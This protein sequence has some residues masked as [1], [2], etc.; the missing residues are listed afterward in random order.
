[1]LIINRIKRSFHLL[2]FSPALPFLLILLFSS[3]AQADISGSAANLVI[4][5]QGILPSSPPTAL[6]GLNLQTNAGDRLY[7]VSVT[8]YGVWGY[9]S[10][11]L[12]SVYL[13]HDSNYNH[14]FDAGDTLIA[15]A[16]PGSPLMVGGGYLIPPDDNGDYA[17]IDF[18]IAIRTS[19]TIR[20]G[21]AFYA[22]VY[23]INDTA[24][25]NVYG[26][27]SG[28]ISCECKVVDVYYEYSLSGLLPPYLDLVKDSHN[29][30][31]SPNYL[32]Y[33]ILTEMK[34][35]NEA[36]PEGASHSWY[37]AE[38]G[39]Y[40]YSY[41]TGTEGL[42][43]Q[44]LAFSNLL[45]F[46][47]K[48]RLLQMYQPTAL[49]ALKLAGK[50][51]GYY[52]YLSQIVVEFT[53]TDS[54]NFNAR[55]M[56]FPLNVWNES[57]SG[58]AVYKD[59]NRNGLLDE[60]DQPLN[61]WDGPEGAFWDSTGNI[62]TLNFYPPDS[63]SQIPPVYDADDPSY[64]AEPHDKTGSDFLIVIRA[65]PQTPLVWNPIE[66]GADFTAKV[67]S[68]VTTAGTTLTAKPDWHTTKEIKA[69]LELSDYT[70]S[71]V[72]P[73]SLF[74]VIG[75]N[76]VDGPD[77]YEKIYNIKLQIKDEVGF[78][79]NTDLSGALLYQDD[80]SSSGVFD[81]NDTIPSGVIRSDWAY[82]VTPEGNFWE[83][84]FSASPG[85]DVPDDD[86][87]TNQ[88]D[89]Y[90][91]V[92]KTSAT[93]GYK[94]RLT[95]RIPDGGI[96]FRNQP[97][98]SV[99][100]G[101]MTNALLPPESN[102]RVHWEPYVSPET[103]L[104]G[105]VS[106][107]FHVLNPSL[108]SGGLPIAVLG[109][110]LASNTTLFTPVLKS[111]VVQLMDISGGEID[112]NDLAEM[113]ADSRVSGLGIWRDNGDGIFNSASDSPLLMV[114][115]P[116]QVV[117][118]AAENYQRFLMVLRDPQPVNQNFSGR[119]DYFITVKTK[120]ISVGDQFILRLWGS[121]MK[122]P[123]SYALGFREEDSTV[124]STEA[125]TYDVSGVT[126]TTLTIAPPLGGS[127]SDYDE[128]WY[129]IITAGADSAK[130]KV[131]KITGVNASRTTI[132]CQQA[133]FSAIGRIDQIKVFKL[134]STTYRNQSTSLT[135]TGEYSVTLSATSTVTAITLRWIDGT[136]AGT[137]EFVIERRDVTSG[138]PFAVIE[139][140]SEST[141]PEPALVGTNTWEYVD[142]SP[143][144]IS[145]HTYQYRV[146]VK[147]SGVGS[148]TSNTVSAQLASYAFAHKPE[149]LE[150]AAGIMVVDL[151]WDW[152]DGFKVLEDGFLVERKGASQPSSAFT[153]I[154]W[155]DGNDLNWASYTDYA[156]TD[157]MLQTEERYH[158][159]VRAFQYLEGG[160][161]G[162]SDYSNV[163]EIEVIPSF[164]PTLPGTGHGSGGCFIATAAYGTPFA[165]EVE[166]LRL[167]RDR[168]LVGYRWGRA[169]IR[170]YYRHSPP[171][172]Q[173]LK[174][175][176]PIWRL[177]VRTFL[178][179]VV[180]LV[181]LLIG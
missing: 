29:T 24:I 169:F 111:F 107:K 17:G 18:F 84:T 171:I 58:V 149:N 25:T 147:V 71:R 77:L 165:K 32:G 15:S 119:P 68:L 114:A 8:F 22:T 73:N 150:A 181:N 176:S 10:S 136:P 137:K 145:G 80:G 1:M 162:Y 19:T 164:D 96:E 167:F 88:G 166:S 30:Y 66:Y 143:S 6:I 104:L 116:T 49:L 120:A 101:L 135:F 9:S 146:T 118:I 125:V 134:E 4:E 28:T 152:P 126:T 27:S 177:L 91:L 124:E 144:L 100:T 117:G 172:A 151:R 168:Y 95:C 46:Q 89:D 139:S 141:L 99:G 127:D 92:L 41:L 87:D 60:A 103:P 97:A 109:L 20:H 55:N 106:V 26:V 154:G 72:D 42:A 93:F 36:D 81:S 14:V 90:Y 161:L 79:P 110:E 48:R 54:P 174:T 39:N 47:R 131:E 33:S 158:Y 74:P 56:L 94:D 65:L 173:F 63:L 122:P 57:E 133:N 130:G 148:F 16:A 138:S 132:T 142:D 38:L 113:S 112:L 121:E 180:W 156:F 40:R 159:R 83:T 61:I 3:P 123:A 140:G 69:V 153:V 128:N 31:W 75:I 37:L 105:N 62:V 13:Y 50:N 11:D 86:Q 179:P 21:D 98:S 59:T 82:V 35:P 53:D 67:T 178:T 12:L 51:Y 45:K 155:V 157:T 70:G 108:T 34:E 76:V 163:V 129:V 44:R 2:L 43:E 78:N 175:H 115:P 23:T 52:D 102:R 85:L 170:F 7:K 64:F 160:T 5:N